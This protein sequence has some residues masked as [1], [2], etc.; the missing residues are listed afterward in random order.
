M[1][2]MTRS[3]K[4]AQDSLR[5]IKKKCGQTL[6]KSKH[7]KKVNSQPCYATQIHMGLV[8]MPSYKQH[9][10]QNAKD[11]QHDMVK[12]SLVQMP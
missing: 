6:Q 5:R 7:T 1:A 9:A 12:H 2:G 4:V 10:Q 11:C 3:K 8:T